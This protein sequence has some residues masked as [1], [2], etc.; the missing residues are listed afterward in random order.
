MPIPEA[1]NGGI[2]NVR[3]NTA[4]IPPKTTL[5]IWDIL[6][7]RESLKVFSIADIAPNIA[8]TILDVAE[9]VPNIDTAIRAK[10]TAIADFKVLRPTWIRL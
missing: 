6:E 5:I 1:N 4:I 7:E 10:I 9:V 3:R 2:F 8:N